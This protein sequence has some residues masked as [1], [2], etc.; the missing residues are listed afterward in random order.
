MVGSGQRAA[1][2]LPGVLSYL[3]RRILETVTAR[4]LFHPPLLKLLGGWKGETFLHLTNIYGA[5]TVIQALFWV[6][7]TCQ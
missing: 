3:A 4:P 6:L 5:P 2:P 7:G 1:R